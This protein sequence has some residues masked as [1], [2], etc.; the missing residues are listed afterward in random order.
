VVKLL[1]SFHREK[2]NN[3]DYIVTDIESVV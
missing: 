1:I 2:K 3:Q